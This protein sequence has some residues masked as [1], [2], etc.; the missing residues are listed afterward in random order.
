[1]QEARQRCQE[2]K[3]EKKHCL[4]QEIQATEEEK[5]RKAE[6]EDRKQKEAEA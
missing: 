3:V 5:K 1:L 4:L 2:E 6:K